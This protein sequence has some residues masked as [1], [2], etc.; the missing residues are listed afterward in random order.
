MGVRGGSYQTLESG[1][2]V[3]NQVASWVRVRPVFSSLPHIETFHTPFRTAF[4]GARLN[5]GHTHTHG[6]HGTQGDV[7]H[8]LS[9]AIRRSSFRW[10]NFGLGEYCKMVATQSELV[11]ISP[12]Q[13]QIRFTHS[14]GSGTSANNPLF[15]NKPEL[16]SF[17]PQFCSGTDLLKAKNGYMPSEHGSGTLHY[18]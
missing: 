5:S 2:G 8:L 7:F 1:S 6:Y 15:R 16:S 14:Q 17:I 4:I 10:T 12:V 13:R 11:R 18:R 9:S 3:A